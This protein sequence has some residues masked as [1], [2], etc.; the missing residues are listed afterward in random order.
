MKAAVIGVGDKLPS[1]VSVKVHAT[2]QREQSGLVIPYDAVYFSAGDAYVYCVENGKLVKTPIQFDWG[3]RLL[4]SS[5][6]VQRFV[7]SGR[8]PD[9]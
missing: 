1:G 4:K 6:G 5:G 9:D 3:G 7:R 2:T 8:K